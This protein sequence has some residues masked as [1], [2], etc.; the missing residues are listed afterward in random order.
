M[1]TVRNQVA[2]R[3]GGLGFGLRAFMNGSFEKGFEVFGPILGTGKVGSFDG[4][5]SDR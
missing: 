5:N 4:S 3:T 2:G 1:I